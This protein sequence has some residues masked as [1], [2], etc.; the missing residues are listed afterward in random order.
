[1]MR[2][3]TWDWSLNKIIVDPEGNIMSGHHRVLAAELAGLPEIPKDSIHLATSVTR[4][5]VYA[6]STILKGSGL[7]GY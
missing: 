3:G 2:N 1:M 4:R 6:W 5:P 7:F